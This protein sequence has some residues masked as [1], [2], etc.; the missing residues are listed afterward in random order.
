M[1]IASRDALKRFN[2]HEAVAFAKQGLDIPD[3]NNNDEKQKRLDMLL[4]LAIA[5][6]TLYGF[7]FSEAGEAYKK[8]QAL[9][10]EVG[11][12][13]TTIHVLFGLWLHN[14]VLGNLPESLSV[15]PTTGCLLSNQ[16]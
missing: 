14:W 3:S 11:T 13:K 9:N 6:T 10:W 7:S 15:R 12:E 16:I 1:G 2:Y 5:L 8:A 4:L